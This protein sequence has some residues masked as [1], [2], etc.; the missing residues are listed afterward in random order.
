MIKQGYLI[1]QEV[2]T[3][4]VGSYKSNSR[5]RIYDK[6]QEQIVH[7]G[8]KLEKALNCKGWVRFEAVM[9]NEY[10]HQLS[11]ELMKIQTDDEFANLIAHAIAQKYRFM[12]VDNGIAGTPTEYT[13]MI[14][15]C[16]SNQQF[17][18]KA[19][20]TRN[21]ALAR[22]IAYIFS[23]SGIMNTL[24][25][26]KEIWGLNAVIEMLEYMLEALEDDFKPNDECRYWLNK[27][28]SDYKNQYKDFDTYM[29]S[30]VKWL[31]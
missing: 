28:C 29:K 13:Q 21:Y 27:N 25:K 2:Q 12:E 3:I 7:K 19:N 9:R 5:L 10:A 22:S 4:Y 24:Y 26:L 11:S 8:S 20:A 18:L 16:L 23:G 6:K 14:L 1:E 31:L 17:Q 15:D 30:D